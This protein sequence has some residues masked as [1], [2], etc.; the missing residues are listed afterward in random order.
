MYLHIQKPFGDEDGPET[1]MNNLE[2]VNEYTVI[3]LLYLTFGFVNNWLS[4]IYFRNNLGI[5]F[6][7][8]VVGNL[9]THLYFLIK[10]SFENCKKKCKEK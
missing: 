10:A 3:V 7:I 6:I 9:C 1:L 8:V 4:S 2:L 5:I